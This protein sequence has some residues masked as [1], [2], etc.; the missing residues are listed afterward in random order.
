MFNLLQCPCDLPNFVPSSTSTQSVSMANLVDIKR[1]HD[2]LYHIDRSRKWIT[3]E[4][5]RIREE[6]RICRQGRRSIASSGSRSNKIGARKPTKRWHLQ[7]WSTRRP[8]DVA[9]SG[10][11]MSTPMQLWLPLGPPRWAIQPRPQGN[12]KRNAWRYGDEL[13]EGA[14]QHP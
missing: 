5:P 14:T 9:M 3:S 6:F 2:G 1:F 4:E 8:E 12:A 13:R 7:N 10:D 11:S